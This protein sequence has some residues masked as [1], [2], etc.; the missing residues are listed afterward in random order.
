M[1]LGMRAML[2]ILAGGSNRDASEYYGQNIEA[3]EM[4]DERL[5]LLLSNGKKISI[6]DNGQDCCESR[7]MTTDDDIQSLV[8]ASLVRIE[9]K[10]G[11]ETVGEDDN[12]HEIVFVEVGTD[13]GFI[14]IVNHNEHNGYYGGFALTITE[15]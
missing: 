10:P 13:K 14:T 12:A 7:Y 4:K 6:F 11:P 5:V 9:S 1:V 8:G 3:V 15:E 2:A